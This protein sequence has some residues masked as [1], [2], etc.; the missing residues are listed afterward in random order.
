MRPRASDGKPIV[1]T[2]PS[3][4]YAEWWRGQQGPAATLLDAN[5]I[6]VERVDRNIAHR[7]GAVLAAVK[8]RQGRGERLL[9]VDAVVTAA[10]RGDVIYTSDVDDLEYIR[11]AA[12]FEVKI[13]RV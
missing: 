6:V 11:D 13:C 7:V 8:R 10:A 1:V 3:V 5:G 12:D 9:L 4:V 2:T